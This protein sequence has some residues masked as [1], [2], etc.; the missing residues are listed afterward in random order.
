M[1]IQTHEICPQCDQRIYLMCHPKLRSDDSIILSSR[2][3]LDGTPHAIAD[4][5]YLDHD[6]VFCITAFDHKTRTPDY[7]CLHCSWSVP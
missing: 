4:G 2:K 3:S 7:Y 5:C 1:L 6:A